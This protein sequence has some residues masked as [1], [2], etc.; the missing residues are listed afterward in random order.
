MKTYVEINGT[1]YEVVPQK[2][3]AEDWK[4]S[5]EQCAAAEFSFGAVVGC[6][7]YPEWDCREYDTDTYNVHLER[8]AKP[9]IGLN[10]PSEAR[11]RAI[12]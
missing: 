8:L 6:T 1:V 3:G 4:P 9:L 2:F 11:R 5:C 7:V 12:V 10:T